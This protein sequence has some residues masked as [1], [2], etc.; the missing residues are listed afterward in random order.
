MES[1]AIHE[2]PAPSDCRECCLRDCSKYPQINRDKR[3]YHHL[4]RVVQG[5]LAVLP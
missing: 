4:A 1:K 2:F 3:Q 5:A